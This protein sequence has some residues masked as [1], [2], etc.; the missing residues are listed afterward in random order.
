MASSPAPRSLTVLIADDDRVVTHVLERLFLERGH[1][2]HAAHDASEAAALSGRIRFDAAL[3]DVNMPGG[4]GAVVEG[5]VR[6]GG[7]R[8]PVLVITGDPYA[9]LDEGLPVTAVVVKPFRFGELVERVEAL[10]GA[11]AGGGEAA[12]D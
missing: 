4:G 8:G 12:G 3:V 10:A 11:G 2:P 7:V 5:L 9:R 6:D 1:R